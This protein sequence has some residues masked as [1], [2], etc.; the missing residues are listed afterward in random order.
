[1]APNFKVDKKQIS[2]FCNR[3]GIKRLALFGSVLRKDFKPNSDIDVLVEF[4][5][6]RSPGFIKLYSIESDLSELFGGRK[7][8]LVTPNSLNHKIRKIVESSAVDQYV[9]K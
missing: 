6:D 8:D 7:L 9:K 4:E 3:H 1:M 5:P 2:E